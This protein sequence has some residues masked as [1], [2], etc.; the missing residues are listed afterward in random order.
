[1]GEIALD[2]KGTMHGVFVCLVSL[3][4]FC[5]NVFFSVIIVHLSFVLFIVLF[6]T[7]MRVVHVQVLFWRAL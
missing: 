7:C 4:I 6:L 3:E 1:M 5:A 2:R